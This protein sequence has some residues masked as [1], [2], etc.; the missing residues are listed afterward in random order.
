ML[1]KLGGWPPRRD[2]LSHEA[3]QPMVTA[4]RGSTAPVP[5]HRSYAS[6]A[7]RRSD[8]PGRPH[9]SGDA[10]PACAMPPSSAAAPPTDLAALPM[11]DFALLHPDWFMVG[12]DD[13]TAGR[14]DGCGLVDGT[15]YKEPESA[16]LLTQ[17]GPEQLRAVILAMCMLAIEMLPSPFPPADCAF[18]AVLAGETGRPFAWVDLTEGA[19][20]SGREWFWSADRN[21]I[22][23]NIEMAVCGTL[24]AA[25][26][27]ELRIAAMEAIDRARR[28]ASSRGY[29]RQGESSADSWPE[30]RAAVLRTLEPLTDEQRTIM[31]WW[32]RACPLPDL[33]RRLRTGFPILASTYLRKMAIELVL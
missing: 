15:I 30:V 33:F 13:R 2:V 23:Y 21:R 8:L 19:A 10:A 1:A 31:L 14:L 32:Q 18:A 25:L 6:L 17:A 12:L 29:A 20:G 9:H 28:A 7:V 22:R 11:W 16:G 24:W 27:D 26:G 4:A 3:R 5:P